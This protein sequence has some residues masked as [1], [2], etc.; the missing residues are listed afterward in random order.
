[1]ATPS[2][3]HTMRR[4]A[5]GVAGGGQEVGEVLGSGGSSATSPTGS[6]DEGARDALPTRLRHDK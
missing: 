4:S 5:G 1:M 3:V 2:T 6:Y